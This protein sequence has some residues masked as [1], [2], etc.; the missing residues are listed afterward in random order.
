MCVLLRYVSLYKNTDCCTKMLFFRI[1]VACN[2]E[3]YL[4]LHVKCPMFLSHCNQIWGSPPP[5]RF[6]WKSPISNFTKI[7]PVRVALIR[8][9]QTDGHDEAN[10][11]FFTTIRTRLTN[12]VGP[13]PKI[14]TCEN[15][16][17]SQ[18]W[19][20]R[21]LIFFLDVTP[22]RFIEIYRRPS[23]TLRKYD[24]SAGCM[25]Y[26]IQSNYLLTTILFGDQEA[27]F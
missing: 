22:C 19:L 5:D 27:M 9:G 24:V 2:N 16:G 17:F 25:F 15:L 23:D 14:I 4:G 21:V 10:R 20:G 12:R 8:A 26:C 7:H 11:R 6:S 13:E 18:R 1:Y 3:T